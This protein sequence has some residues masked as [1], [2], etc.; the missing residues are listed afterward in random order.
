MPASARRQTLADHSCAHVLP[1]LATRWNSMSHLSHYES[2]VL[3]IIG[4]RQPVTGYSV[5]KAL[6]ER[7]ATNSSDSPGSTY[8][9]IA[10]LKRA[11]LIRATIDTSDRRRTTHLWCTDE[12]KAAIKEWIT[13]IEPRDLVPEDPFRTRVAFADAIEP[14]A[15]RDWLY[16]MRDALEGARFTI[17]D[18]SPERSNDIASLEH[19]NA[20][21]LTVA[22]IAW[23]DRAIAF[24]TRSEP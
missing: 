22:R 7:I 24:T 4:K 19:A 15:F 11:G 5:R 20:H 18:G 12:G 17:I 23:V 21:L 6:M 10:R 3:A 14:K 8:P 2:H 13:S 1:A 9:A 16:A